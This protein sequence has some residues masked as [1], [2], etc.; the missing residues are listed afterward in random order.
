MFSE[1][2]ISVKEIIFNQSFGSFMKQGPNWCDFLLPWVFRKYNIKVGK[3]WEEAYAVIRIFQLV[4]L[5][6]K[7]VTS[8]VD[9]WKT[10]VSVD[11]DDFLGLLKLLWKEEN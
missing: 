1:E 5:I 7:T 3:F 6:R 8:C 11:P 9:L 4:C 2:D 10:N